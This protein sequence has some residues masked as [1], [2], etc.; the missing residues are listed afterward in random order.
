[1]PGGFTT[2][3]AAVLNTLFLL[4]GVFIYL[5][6]M[7]QIAARARYVD[8]PPESR[9]FG[10]PEAVVA[11][12]LGALFTVNAFAAASRT[13]KVVLQTG[14]LVF[15]ALISLALLV[16]IAAFLHF[17]GIDVAGSFARLR[18]GRAAVTAGVLLFAAYPLLVVADL[19]TQQVLGGPSSRQSIVEMFAGLTNM[20]QRVII[21]VLA[22][23]IA[24][25]VEE[26]VFRFFIYG[27]L[28]RYFG[29]FVGLLLNATLFAIVHAHV[30]SALP[31]FVLGACFTL[32]YEWSGSIVVPMTMHALFNA[33]TLTALAFPQALPQ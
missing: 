18:F 6:L 1:M 28:K 22:V 24:P 19:L 23:V 32:A 26:F 14:D 8:V 16:F 5:A 4:G 10:I 30:P 7:K 31:L 27:V 13:G 15:N 12:L 20:Q 3:L 25:L 11:L 29:R 21:I 9:P 33:I 2:A 17:R